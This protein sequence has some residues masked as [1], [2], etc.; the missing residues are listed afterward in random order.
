MSRFENYFMKLVLTSHYHRRLCNTEGIESVFSRMA[1]DRPDSGRD[2]RSL[3]FSA[4]QGDHFAKTEEIWLVGDKKKGNSDVLQ[5]PEFTAPPDSKTVVAAVDDDAASVASSAPRGRE[6][7][8]GMHYSDDF[9]ALPPTIAEL[10]A[11]SPDIPVV[12]LRRR[13]EVASLN[14]AAQRH[15][16]RREGPAVRRLLS[17]RRSVIGEASDEL[18][19]RALFE[20]AFDDAAEV[21]TDVS[22]SD[23]SEEDSPP[24]RAWLRKKNLERAF[25]TRK[26]AAEQMLLTEAAMKE[27]ER[28][29]FACENE[30]RQLD[31]ADA[32]LRHRHERQAEAAEDMKLRFKEMLEQVKEVQEDLPPQVAAL[33]E[34]QT[35]LEKALA[36]PALRAKRIEEKQAELTT[37]RH[38][39]ADIEAEMAQAIAEGDE[40]KAA[41]AADEERRRKK[42]EKDREREDLLLAEKQRAL[43]DEEAKLESATLAWQKA[44]G[45]ARRKREALNKTQALLD[46]REVAVKEG[47]ERVEKL[48]GGAMKEQ[49]ALITQDREKLKELEHEKDAFRSRISTLETEDGDARR[50]EK[51]VEGPLI[52]AERKMFFLHDVISQKQEL[53][54][55]KN[56]LFMAGLRAKVEKLRKEARF[57]RREQ[58]GER[59]LVMGR[60]GELKSHIRIAAHHWERSARWCA[61]EENDTSAAESKVFCR[62]DL[63]REI[64]EPLRKQFY[65]EFLA[66]QKMVRAFFALR[67][68][69]HELSDAVPL[70]AQ[71]EELREGGRLEERARERD[72]KLRQTRAET[73]NGIRA[74]QERQKTLLRK[75]RQ[76][77]GGEEEGLKRFRKAQL[78]AEQVRRALREA[79]RTAAAAEKMVLE[80]PDHERR[81]LEYVQNSNFKR[82]RNSFLNI[83]D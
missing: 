13:W 12:L 47:W 15:C 59:R 73:E 28:L 43:H 39:L 82:I 49:Q 27:L 20:E 26:V 18:L 34:K 40:E 65:S 23:S 54:N 74:L 76:L 48:K 14:S 17:Q 50:R 66:T 70:L 32:E 67:D 52:E 22:S 19:E 38:T 6:F 80:E 2:I 78:R 75:E 1:A 31:D 24:D 33:R 30:E 10:D 44:D 53:G 57:L 81:N 45:E 63:W 35:E 58:R 7:T 3:L 71:V 55:Q 21:S 79:Q 11:V 41:A 61:V 68:D 4:F 16:V 51:E 8:G 83:C 56:V 42:L 77:S 25:R 37:A 9:P 69:D 29:H 36:G 64:P 46:A 72:V 5:L 62:D 60:L